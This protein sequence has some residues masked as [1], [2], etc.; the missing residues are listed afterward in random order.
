MDKYNTKPSSVSSGAFKL[1]NVI[2]ICTKNAGLIVAFIAC[3][4]CALT[5]YI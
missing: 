2:S 5:G 4:I 1:V 3:Y